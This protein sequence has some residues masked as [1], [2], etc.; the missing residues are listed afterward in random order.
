VVR[1]SVGVARAGG[2]SIAVM[3]RSSA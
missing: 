1:V 2:P 3:V